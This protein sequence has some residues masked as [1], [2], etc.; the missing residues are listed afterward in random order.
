MISHSSTTFPLRFPT[1][2][3]AISIRAPLF[4]RNLANSYHAN[5]L[6]MLTREE[7]VVLDVLGHQ[8]VLL[9]LAVVYQAGARGA[10]LVVRLGF[11]T[12]LR[13]GHA[14]QRGLG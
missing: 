3:V 12:G 8:L 14:E 7:L 11:R 1:H 13:R 4:R 9:V 2:T 10:D 5:D 6:I